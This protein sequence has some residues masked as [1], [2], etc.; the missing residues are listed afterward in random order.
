MSYS[1]D[2]GQSYTYIVG[3]ANEGIA[4]NQSAWYGSWSTSY[5]N[6]SKDVQIEPTSSSF[7]IRIEATANSLYC[8][9]YT[10][11]YEANGGTSTDPTL[12]VY[13]NSIGFGEKAINPTEPYEETFEVT[14][15]NLTQNLSVSVGSGLTGVSVSPETISTSPTTVTV[16]YNPTA[17]GSISGNIT[18]S[19]TDDNVSETVAVTGSAYDPSIVPTYALVTDVNNLSAGDVI[20]LGCANHNVVSGSFNS[21]Y[22]LKV[23]ATIS[24]NSVSVSDATRFTLGKNG[25]DWTLSFNDGDLLGCSGGDLAKGSTSNTTTN[26]WG[27]SISND[28]TA[29]ITAK[30]S[31]NTIK[32]NSSSPRFKTYTSGQT[33][34]EIYKLVN[35]NQVATPSF[36]VPTGT[37]YAPQSVELLCSTPEAV[38]HYTTDGSVPTS[39]SEV[40]LS[41]IAVSSTQTIK[42]IA[43]KS[44]MEDSEV[45]TAV[46]TIFT[47]STYSLVTSIESGRHY[48]ITNGSTKAMGMQNSNNR[49]AVDVEIEN[50]VASVSSADVYEFVIN[51]PEFI[52]KGEEEIEVYT[53]YDANASSTGFLYAA[54]SGSNYLR[55][56]THLDADNN[57]KWAITFDGNKAVIKAQGTN[58]R[59]W[60][61]YNTQSGFFSCYESTSQQTSDEVYLYLKDETTPQYDFYKDIT[62]YGSSQ[63]GYTLI[64]SPIDGVNPANVAGMTDGNFDLYRFNESAELEWENW[65]QE[66]DHNHFNLE[67]GKGYLYAHKT[68]VTL[69]FAGTPVQGATFDVTLNK[70]TDAQYEGVNLVGNP[71]GQTA[72]IDRDF[73]VMNQAGSE[74]IT[75]SGAIAPMQG[76]IVGAASHGETLTFTT[77]APSNGGGSKVAINLA[78]NRGDVI[79]RAIVRFG[80]G[81][82]LHKF[83]LRENSTKVYFTEGNQ[84]FAVV[85]SHEAQGEMPVNFKAEENGTYTLNINTENVEMN[86]LHLIDNMTG[87]DVDLLQTPSYTFDATTNDYT[88]RFRLVFSANDVNEQNAETFAFFSNGNWVVN[89]EGEATLQ[90]IDVNGRIVSNETI[91]GSVATSINATPGVYMLRLVNGNEVKTQKIVVR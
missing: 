46:Y 22:L 40:Y 30:N 36:S 61:L 59:N 58:S 26:I 88:S 20:I 65:K 56:E 3:S 38:I 6:I 55:T 77:Q 42:A 31:S 72:Y 28:G 24:N 74:F 37:Y 23:D 4:F 84:D 15:A 53:I 16:S 82:Q 70:T 87:M 14:F 8:Q 18:V 43:V 85:R 7:I 25:N 71:F 62:G 13:P 64:A 79:D 9:S 17:T 60:M 33:S 32:Y 27:I 48:I 83:Q 80:E 69:A 29:N 10:L 2:G 49:A 44:G 45:A 12:S 5:V 91:N 67:R 41:A 81:R 35:T 34:I 39:E 1:I 76:I 73:Y 11:T 52:T 68:D 86:Y 63:Y 21:K 19:N 90:V 50:G 54:S 57:G 51:G 47:P 66:G 75:S 89:N 78:R